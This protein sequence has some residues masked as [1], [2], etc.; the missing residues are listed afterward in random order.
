MSPK[1]KKT[2]KYVGGGLVGIIV[3]LVVA[4]MFIDPPQTQVDTSQQEAGSGDQRLDELRVRNEELDNVFEAGETEFAQPDASDDLFAEVGELSDFDQPREVEEVSRNDS[5]DEQSAPFSN[6]SPSSADNVAMDSPDDTMVDEMNANA[7][8]LSAGD[9]TSFGDAPMPSIAQEDIQ[10]L[11]DDVFAAL[12]TMELQLSD[13]MEQLESAIDQQA[14][15]QS[16][17]DV[18]ALRESVLALAATQDELYAQIQDSPDEQAEL[19]ARVEQLESQ[20]QQRQARAQR[21]SDST[22]RNLYRL[23]RIQGNTAVL[24]GQNTGTR[25]TFSEGDSLAYNGSVSAIRGD[26]VTLR[27]PTTSVTLSIY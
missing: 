14:S 5:T 21:P 18:A 1:V 12:S 23:D 16:G 27:W 2:F 4:G 7:D 13:E 19:V 10:Q 22:L 26:S 20:L 9:N 15:S 24:I 8:A 25:F 11:K 3:L 17:L 6:N